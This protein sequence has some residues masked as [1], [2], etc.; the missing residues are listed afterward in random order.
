MIQNPGRSGSGVG[1]DARQATDSL[2]PVA[3]ARFD[4]D[5]GAVR[6]AVQDQVRFDSGGR[7]PKEK[8]R[9]RVLQ[10]FA[11]DDVLDDKRLPARAENRMAFQFRERGRKRFQENLIVS[12]LIAR[13]EWIRLM[14]TSWRPQRGDSLHI[15]CDAGADLF[16]SRRLLARRHGRAN[17]VSR[18]HTQLGNGLRSRRVIA[19]LIIRPVSRGV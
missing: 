12:E 19:E 14:G 16:T 3:T 13:R 17:L 8:L 10:P 15:G 18:L 6:A 5:G 2:R 1:D 9:V 7:P 11:A 4:F